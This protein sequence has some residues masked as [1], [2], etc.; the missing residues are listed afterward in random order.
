MVYSLMILI[1][2]FSYWFLYISYLIPLIFSYT[3]HDNQMC[4][5]IKY[6]LH[7]MLQLYIWIAFGHTLSVFPFQKNN[8]SPFYFF[9]TQFH[10]WLPWEET[11]RTQTPVER[12]GSGHRFLFLWRDRVCVLL[13]GRLQDDVSRTEN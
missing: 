4:F 12:L 11:H 13:P 5:L 3:L 1:W 7:F 2:L 6:Y 8:I 10:D 9:L